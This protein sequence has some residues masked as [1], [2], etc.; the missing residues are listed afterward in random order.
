M[1]EQGGVRRFLK[2]AA[3]MDYEEFLI[4]KEEG[5]GDLGVRRAVYGTIKKESNYRHFDL[6]VF[7]D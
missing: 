5:C 4:Q 3:G 2:I 6:F 7:A 1:D